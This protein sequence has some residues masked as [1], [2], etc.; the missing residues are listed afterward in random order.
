MKK[1]FWL[2]SSVL[3]GLVS[4]ALLTS[5]VS[6]DQVPIQFLGINDFHGALN[7]TG[8]ANMPEGRISGAG[9]A[10]VLSTYLK[11]AESD[12][13]STNSNGHSLR[14]QSG[15][16]V[17]A[18]PANSGL[19]Q[20]EP[21]IRVLNAM[22]FDYGTLGNHEFD[23]GLDEFNRIITGQAPT[24]GKFYSIVDTYPREASTQKIVIANVVDKATGAIPY[25]F[26]PYE[27]ESINVNGQSVKVGFIGILT[28]E[29]PSL[30]LK[31]HH[32][33]YNFL[34]EAETI[35][36]YAK[37]LRQQGVNAIV[38]LSHVSAISPGGVVGG[39]AADILSKVASIDPENSVDLMFTGHSHTY[40]NGLYGHTRVVQS[41]SQ[42]RA[43]SDVRGILDT[44]TQDFV[45]APSA[46]IVATAPGVEKDTNV[47]AIVNE[48]DSIVA[49]VT[50]A[51]IGTAVSA[52][53]IT[54]EV[55]EFKESPLG[56]LITK[57]QLEIARKEG[58][59]ADFAITNNG[60]IRSDLLVKDD[61][62]IT[63]G[64][65]Q[66]VQPFG[67]I[68]QVVELSGQQ[69]YDTLNQQY[70]ESEKYFLQMSGLK[71]VYTDFA[72]SATENTNSDQAY[73][74]YKAYKEDGTEIDPNANYT[75][76][77][78][79][80]LYGGGDSFSALTGGRFLGAISPDTEVFVSYIK[81]LE[82]AGKPVAA[83]I[84]GVKTYK[85]AEQIA[86]EQRTE[87]EV[88]IPFESRRI[89]DANLP[90]GSEEVVTKG[91]NGKALIVKDA[92]GNEISRT[93]LLEPITEVIHVGTKAVTKPGQ[94]TPPGST[95]ELP[96][97][98][99]APKNKKKILP[100]TGES[101]GAI[102]SLLGAS[103]LGM[104]AY[105]KKRQIK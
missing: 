37:Q 75:V 101:V 99:S 100:A 34:D 90:L 84:N 93:V 12:F 62:S 16:M 66:A 50:E 51:K 6:A 59:N 38:V 46:T 83:S 23:E 20:D 78:N 91:V 2:K 22:D 71:Y 87:E 72:N 89:D 30:V 97:S 95:T 63:W 82:E 47:Q 88:I 14:V 11:N 52:D 7:T 21:T 24:A 8:S 49:T 26:K 70:D 18:S 58:Y 56:N 4:S 44:A 76:V 55:N 36:Y 86:A 105:L 74:V 69:I 57:A 81:S 60:G 43:Y 10:A 1:K 41:L 25:G 77:I 40:A 98:S 31:Q 102:W 15:D 61:F 39:Q 65:A 68:L 85:S 35:A 3:T 32:E 67:N 28:T 94:N 27:V 104:A 17:G 96:T 53:T 45:E 29:V 42:G 13:L 19:L 64:A 9:S 48:A 79:D 80:F 54:R 92:N 5:V 103:G 33:G 73:K